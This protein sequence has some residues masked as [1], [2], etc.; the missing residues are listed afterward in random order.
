[1][2]ISLSK[3]AVHDDIARLKEIIIE[4]FGDKYFPQSTDSSAASKIE[5][6][7]MEVMRDP[8]M[9]TLDPKDIAQ[10]LLKRNVITDEENEALARK[11]AKDQRQ[12]VRLAVH[13]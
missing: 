8:R 7:L 5:E 11:E 4:Y 13:F 1:M 2:I 9:K 10:C 6:F 3:I 12:I